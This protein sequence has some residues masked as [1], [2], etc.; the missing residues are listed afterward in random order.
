MKIKGG[1]TTAIISSDPKQAQCLMDLISGRDYYG[2]SKGRINVNGIDK[3][4]MRTFRGSIGY[5][6]KETILYDQFAVR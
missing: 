4:S 2:W 1:R 6:S 5:V 3:K